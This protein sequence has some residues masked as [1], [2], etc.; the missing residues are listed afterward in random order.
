M[1]QG[2]IPRDW[3]PGAR[4]RG[5]ALAATDSAQHILCVLPVASRDPAPAV[6]GRFD[7]DSA[8]RRRE[9]AYSRSVPV[10]GGRFM[11]HRRQSPQLFAEAAREA[12]RR[13]GE[14]S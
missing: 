3:A 11:F 7:S 6:L 2:R 9:R 5:H 14:V 4:C 13:Q 8:C 10:G 1:T 12:R